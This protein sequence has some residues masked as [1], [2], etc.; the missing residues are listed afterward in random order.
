M[1]ITCDAA[2][3]FFVH[4]SQ[5]I[6]GATPDNLPDEGCEYWADGPVCLVFH[7]TAHPDVW[8]AHLAVKPEGLGQAVAPTRRLLEA[9][10]A[11]HKPRCIIAWIEEHRRAAIAFAK[12]AGARET[13]RIPGTVMLDWS[14]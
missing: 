12:R 5:Q 4:P 10:W 8:M 3:E 14:I 7:G 1:R 11:E 2:R 6:L 9:F 13:G